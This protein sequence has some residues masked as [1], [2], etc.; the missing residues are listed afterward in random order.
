MAKIKLLAAALGAYLRRREDE[1]QP[2]P[3]PARLEPFSSIEDYC[4]RERGQGNATERAEKTV[5][6]LKFMFQFQGFRAAS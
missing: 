2:S 5:P 6:G 4:W 3:P 1:A